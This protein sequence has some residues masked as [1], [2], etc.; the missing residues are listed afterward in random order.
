MTRKFKYSLCGLVIILI[1]AASTYIC[2]NNQDD[3]ELV[4]QVA[5]SP[6]KECED[7]IVNLINESK[8]KIDETKQ[9]PKTPEGI[10]YA[11]GTQGTECVKEA[12]I[13]A[14]SPQV[15]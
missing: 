4:D 9:S 11:L 1:L 10:N 7:I 8:E 3:V 14:Q 12:V 15:P 13:A 2:T 6:S 5:F